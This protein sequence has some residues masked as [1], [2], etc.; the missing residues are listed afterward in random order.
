MFPSELRPYSWYISFKEFNFY[1]II[2][3]RQWDIKFGD[4]LDYISPSKYKNTKVV[5]SKFGTQIQTPY[6]PNYA[7]QILLKYGK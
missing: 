1:P 7:N 6:F 4:H 5:N 3:T 2:V